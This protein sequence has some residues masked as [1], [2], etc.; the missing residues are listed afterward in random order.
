M[1]RMIAVWCW[2]ILLRRRK[3]LCSHLNQRHLFSLII[4]L[5]TLRHTNVLCCTSIRSTTV[6]TH[7]HYLLLD[8]TKT[9]FLSC[10]R[11]GAQT[12]RD[13]E[14]AL[15]GWKAFWQY[16]HPNGI[17]QSYTISIPT[18]PLH[19]TFTPRHHQTH[20]PT[21]VLTHPHRSILYSASQLTLFIRATQQLSSL[22]CC[23]LVLVLVMMLV[24]LIMA[25]RMMRGYMIIYCCGCRW[26][27]DWQSYPFLF[28][29]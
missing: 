22:V 19:T 9:S 28:S 10:R 4:T 12:H 7:S 13:M 8:M 26:C 25:M 6:G 3:Q 2:M 15:F 16:H 29:L 20:H 18:Q 1:A 11:A 14:A 17:T 5:H 21:P 23:H 24:M 27:V